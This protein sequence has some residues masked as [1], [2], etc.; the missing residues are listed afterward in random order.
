[1]PSLVASIVLAAVPAVMAAGSA[2]T[3]NGVH[4]ID[5]AE[6]SRLVRNVFRVSMSETL[7]RPKLM[8]TPRHNHTTKGVDHDQEE[9]PREWSA[10]DRG[11][12]SRYAR[13]V[14][15]VRKNVSKVGA[16]WESD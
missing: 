7:S 15:R 4:I 14:R 13:L 2:W 12:R 6:F 1:M 5:V 8:D 11:G 3:D 10:A 16:S 9:G